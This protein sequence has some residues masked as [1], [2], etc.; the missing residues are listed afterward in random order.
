MQAAIAAATTHI[1]T[2]ERLWMNEFAVDNSSAKKITMIVYVLYAIAIFCGVTGL[3]AI[4]VNYVKK[5]DVK[6]TLYESHFRW[7]IRTFWF[8]CLWA[9]LGLLTSFI[10]I[11][12]AILGVAYIWYIYR[13][14]KG[15]LRLNDDK[16][17]Y[18]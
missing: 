15:F 10:L 14:V 12:F 1:A 5:D 2:T 3:V 9:F 17:M 18:V 6:G 4:V 16:A 7:Q 11:G 13:V 8:S